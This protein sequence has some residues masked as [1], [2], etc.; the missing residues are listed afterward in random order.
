MERTPRTNPI[1]NPSILEKVFRSERDDLGTLISVVGFDG[2]G[3]T[4]Q[5]SALAEVFR[6]Q[7]RE[8]VETRQPTDWFRNQ[9]F[10]RSFL[11]HGGSPEQARILALMAAADRLQHVHEVIDP[12]LKQ[13][14]VV[15]CDRYVY[16]T[17]GVFIHRGVDFSFLVTINQGVPKPDHAFYLKLPTEVLIQRLHQRDG[18]KLKFEERSPDRVESIIRT[19]DDMGSQ[20]IVIDGNAPPEQVTQTMLGHIST[21]G[22]GRRS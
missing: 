18:D 16:A 12:A 17:F 15:I 7:G 14:K 13:G 2:S 6:K 10:N 19:Y 9:P 21:K 1:V 22:L 20:L 11:D 8:V 5:I 4:T 3:K